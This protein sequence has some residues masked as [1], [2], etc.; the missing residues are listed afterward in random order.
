MEEQNKD[1]KLIA[2]EIKTREL[3]INEN[4]F[5]DAM[6]SNNVAIEIAKKEYETL[7]NQE[8]IA[9]KIGKVIKENTEVEIETAK[10]KV[11]EKDKDNRVKR[12]E[13]KNDLLRLRNEK[14]Y[15]KKEH[16]HKLEMQ[17]A[18]QIREK[19][20][21]LL[22][23]TCRKKQKDEN[24]KWMFVDDEN[25]R[26]IVNIPN[27]IRLFFLRTFDGL[28]STL[29]QTADIFGLL[30]KNV[31]KGGFIILILLLIF[32]PPLRVWL[33]GLIGIKM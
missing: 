25:G 13:I 23:R 4:K 2:E 31:L 10:I 33:L 3:A 27:K 17:R 21:D 9:K 15:I 19:Y 29:N 22:L 24:G 7:K 12:Q 28:I 20:E 14:I 6:T 11:E 18:R 30:N 16:K 8:G 5:V 32:V 26:P 1:L